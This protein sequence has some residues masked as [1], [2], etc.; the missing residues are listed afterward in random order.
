MKKILFSK[1]QVFVFYLSLLVCF[2]ACKGSDDELK[3]SKENLF[4]NTINISTYSDNDI[5]I[6]SDRYATLFEGIYNAILEEKKR[7]SNLGSNISS[8][9][10][11]IQYATNYIN[12]LTSEEQAFISHMFSEPSEFSRKERYVFM[13]FI[14]SIEPLIF[15]KDEDKL[16]D[17]I[18]AFYNRTIYK[19][20]DL[21]SRQEMK[22][23][24]ESL[25]KVRYVIIN[26]I[27][28]FVRDNNHISRISPGDRMIWS[29]SV[30]MLT[31]DQV[32]LLIDV[33]FVGVG[34][35]ATGYTNT[36][37]SIATTIHAIW[38]CFS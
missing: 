17:E 22:L 18:D 19:S 30:S 24:L 33:T 28:E 16:A 32:H 23:R 12:S 27:N 10:Y 25:K 4:N 1:S 29:Q 15:E 37:I 11:L 3:T 20:F 34:F 36:M 26:G 31:K 35:M 21:S 5:E 6:L 2:G 13:G 8:E 7:I 14:Q 9:D 38:L